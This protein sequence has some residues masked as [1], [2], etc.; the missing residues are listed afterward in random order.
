M[1]KRLLLLAFAVLILAIAAVAGS[2][3]WAVTS[4][5]PHYIAALEEPTES[6]EASSRQLESRFTTLT[7]DLQSRGKWQTVITASELNGWL[8]FKLP[9]SF[10]DMLPE[11]IHDPRITILPDT[12]VAAAR[13]EIAGVKAV[14]SV[15]VEP[16]VT[17][18]GDLAV[19]LKQVLAGSLPVPTKELVDR[20]TR[21]TRRARLPILWTQSGG[22]TV[23]I[24]AREMWD[25]DNGQHRVLEAIELTD[26]KMFLSGR[27]EQV[28][29]SETETL[30]SENRTE[31]PSLNV[32][33]NDVPS[34][35]DALESAIDD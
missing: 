33:L 17:E 22:N 5:Q 2:I 3:Y 23:M 12:L 1:I 14:V 31:P 20:L 25:T 30:E 10:P 28:E 7:S 26:G 32:P 9:E 18:D 11:E 34:N 4:A 13:S 8:A 24:I 16:Y 29:L 15:M 19:E 6:L 21:A 35:S 27:T